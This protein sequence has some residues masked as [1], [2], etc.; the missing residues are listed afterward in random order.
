MEVRTG[1]LS[2]LLVQVFRLLALMESA[3]PRPIS[4]VGSWPE[5][6]SGLGGARSDLLAITLCRALLQKSA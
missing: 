1:T 6:Y 3:G 5:N 4:P 2:G